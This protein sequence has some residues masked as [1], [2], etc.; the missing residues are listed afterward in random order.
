LR[1]HE[2]VIHKKVNN[3]EITWVCRGGTGLEFVEK[4]IP[5]TRNF[6]L[7]VIL[8]GGND[9][10]NGVPPPV[11]ADKLMYLSNRILQEG[12][13]NVCIGSIWPRSNRPFNKMCARLGDDLYRSL[14]QDPS[15]TFWQWDRRLA[16]KNYDGVHLY[17]SGYRNAAHHLASMILWLL[18]RKVWG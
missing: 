5:Q 10:A 17:H 12:V 7:V 1:P 2:G 11:V 6:H 15:I 9:M 4:T 16:Y 18:K 14:Y 13:R 8:S 3:I